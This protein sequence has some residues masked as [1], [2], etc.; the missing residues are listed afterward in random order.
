MFL[1][2]LNT[3][4]LGELPAWPEDRRRLP[5]RV[6]HWTPATVLRHHGFDIDLDLDPLADGLALLGDQLLYGQPS[7]NIRGKISNPS[8]GRHDVLKAESG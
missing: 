4:F 6:A 2:G 8:C 5:V 3:G 7:L 1:P